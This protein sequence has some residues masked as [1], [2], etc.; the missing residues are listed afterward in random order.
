MKL[1]NAILY[2]HSEL[3]NEAREIQTPNLVIWSHTRYRCAIAPCSDRGTSKNNFE[4]S[5][6]SPNEQPVLATH[7]IHTKNEGKEVRIP[8]CLCALWNGQTIKVLP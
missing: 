1:N 3:H 7:F 5:P 6:I 4:H 8:E 2:V